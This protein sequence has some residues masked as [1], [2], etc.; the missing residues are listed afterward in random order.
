MH[1]TYRNLF[2]TAS[3]QKLALFVN[4]YIYKQETVT[5]TR[6]T[7]NYSQKRNTQTEDQ[8]SHIY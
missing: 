2:E 8:V 4:I 3:F 7:F 5:L 1:K 6:Q